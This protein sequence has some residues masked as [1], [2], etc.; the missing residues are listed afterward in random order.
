MKP[1]SQTIRSKSLIL[2]SISS[3]IKQ[4]YEMKFKNRKIGLS[5]L[6]KGSRG[7]RRASQASVNKAFPTGL[8]VNDSE[9]VPV[10]AGRE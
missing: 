1:L 2:G 9:P 8:G 3:T 6:E 10:C 4:R 7:Q 5:H